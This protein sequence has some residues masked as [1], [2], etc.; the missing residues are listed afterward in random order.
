MNQP[1]SL[2]SYRTTDFA[3]NGGY[4]V[5]EQTRQPVESGHAKLDDKNH[6]LRPSFS[7]AGMAYWLVEQH[8]DSRHARWPVALT[9][10]TR[11]LDNY[12]II[13]CQTHTVATAITSP[14]RAGPL[15]YLA[16][17]ADCQEGQHNGGS[18]RAASARPAHQGRPARPFAGS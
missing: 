11:I 13:R 12:Q 15:P 9:Q 10:T 17:A 16:S 4:R 6:A 18:I 5:S 8:R 2:E 1:I 7:F 14:R 3:L